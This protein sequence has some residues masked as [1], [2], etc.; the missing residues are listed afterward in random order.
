M[1]YEWLKI[2]HLFSVFA[3]M[4]GLFYLPRL[5]VYHV[6]AA[7]TGSDPNPGTDMT[8]QIMERRLLRAI[9]N[10][11]MIGTW[12]FGLWLMVEGGFYKSGWMHAKLSLIVIL[13]ISHMVMARHRKQFAANSNQK[14]DKYFRILNEVPTIIL[15]FILILVILKPF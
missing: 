2:L 4:A 5:F 1:L 3:W 10:P 6:A 15:I 11:A 8:L 14:S 7:P 13:T 12:V 9:M